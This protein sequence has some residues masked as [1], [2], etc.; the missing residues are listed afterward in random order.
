VLPS[1]ERSWAHLTRS[2]ELA[3]SLER[4]LPNVHNSRTEKWN[5]MIQ[6]DS[7]N[8]EALCDVKCDACNVAME[9]FGIERHPTIEHTDL[10]TYVCPRCDKLQTQAVSVSAMMENHMLEPV[11]AVLQDKAFDIEAT[12][13]LCSTF[14]AA[15]EAI[16]AGSPP[17]NAQQASLLRELLAKLLIEMVTRGERNPDRLLENALGRSALLRPANAEL[18]AA[19]Q[20]GVSANV[21]R[22][23]RSSRAKRRPTGH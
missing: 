2:C 16:V 5:T 13:L 12:R 21:I 8:A 3:E 20:A 19:A 23:S 1:F 10:R 22:S 11:D 4:F 6:L 9:L 14:D 18:P 15:W 17:S 7:T